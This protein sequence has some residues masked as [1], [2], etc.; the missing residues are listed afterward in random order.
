M[1]KVLRVILGLVIS[2]FFLWLTFRRADWPQVL[3]ILKQT[4]IIFVIGSLLVALFGLILRSYR[5]KLLGKDYRNIPWRYFFRATNI[6][7]MLNTFLP[8][9]SGD[10]FQ[11]YFLSRNSTLPQSYTLATVFLERLMDLLVPLLTIIIG[12]FFVVMPEQLNTHRMILLLVFVLL[13]LGL[14][15]RF[16]RQIVGFFS[17]FL[18]SHHGEKLQRLL[19]NILRAVVFLKDRQ[20]LTRALPLTV[21][22][23]FVYALSNLLVLRSLDIRIGFWGAFLIQSITVMSVTIPSSPGY[24]GTWEFF[25][26]L[27]LTIF[28]VEKNLALSFVVLGHFLALLPT[29]V[30]GLFYFYREVVLK[31]S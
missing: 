21:F 30:L 31:R 20:V 4:K 6:G 3:A 7:L 14:F 15:L 11:S 29:A 19:D 10:F 5:W 2:I 22:L 27:A 24:V 1:K 28:G 13:F 18:H 12:S 26:V 17:N 23:W 16:R 25:G 9:R 8:F